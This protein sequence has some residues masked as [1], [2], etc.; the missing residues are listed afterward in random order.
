MIR[1]PADEGELRSMV[2]QGLLD[3][4]HALELK[5][6]LPPGTA[7]NKELARD[8][9]QFTPDGGV[10]VVGVDEG[11]KTTPPSLTPVD[12]AGLPERIEEVAANR[13]D[14]PLHVRIQTIPAAGQP[15]KGY[16]LVIVPPS[17][18][19]I[20]MV[21]GRYWARGERTRYALSDADVQ[22]YHQLVLKGQR[23]A[24]ELL[25]AEVR[26]DPAAAAGLTTHAHLFAIAQP[27]GARTDLLER[28]I[29][30]SGPQ[31]WHEFLHGQVRGGSAGRPL[32]D[33]WSPD[34]PG[35]G[36]PSRRARGW[37]LRSSGMTAGRDVEAPRADAPRAVDVEKRL[38]DLEVNEDGGLR[39]FCGRASDTLRDED[40]DDDDL[41]CVVEGLVI[42][43]TKRLVLVAET[44]ANTTDWLGSWDFGIA[45]TGL[46]GLVSL[47]LLQHGQEYLAAPFSEDDYRETVRATYERVVK[48]PD[49]IVTDL[50]GRLNRALGGSA[51]IPQ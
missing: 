29:G 28:V 5:R 21:D 48:D 41:E 35:I 2:A 1:L 33:P 26:R 3:E 12:L 30:G 24:A 45:I 32:S 37:A 31:G 14:P 6:E 9:A 39:L 4:G 46:R 18:S 20:H 7:A 44:V 43:L 17:P 25:D 40:D 51:P 38:L 10:V 22:R 47:R 23:D 11:D 8:L 16:L 19:K 34:L 27:V 15:G 36:E 49:S 50:T 42:G 13:V